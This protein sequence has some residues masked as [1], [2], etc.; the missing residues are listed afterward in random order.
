MLMMIVV[1]IVVVVVQMNA[2]DV[3]NGVDRGGDGGGSSTIRCCVIAFIVGRGV[4]GDMV[5]T[6]YAIDI[7]DAVQ[8]MI[9]AAIAAVSAIQAVNG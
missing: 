3:L 4:V 6:I 9:I 2:F 7:I 5:I 8:F 1:V